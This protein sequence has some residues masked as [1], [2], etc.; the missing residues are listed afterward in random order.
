MLL[1]PNLIM[2]KQKMKVGFRLLLQEIDDTASEFRS[3]LV[4]VKEEL[5]RS[6]IK[7]ANE[8]KQNVSVDYCNVFKK[9][10]LETNLEANSSLK[11]QN[12]SGTFQL[13]LQKIDGTAS[14]LCS[15]LVN[16]KEELR[17][18]KIKAGNKR[19]QIVSVD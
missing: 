12:M 18:S 11:D 14:E 3:S 1:P 17:R 7:A 19:K 9:P 6:K 10:T 5:S 2:K 15:N 16:V 8:R 13:I 4:K